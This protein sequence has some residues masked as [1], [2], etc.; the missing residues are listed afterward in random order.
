MKYSVPDRMTMVMK[1]D[2]WECV[3]DPSKT[4]RELLTTVLG[5]EPYQVW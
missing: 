5:D 1:K 3:S 4:A 2:A